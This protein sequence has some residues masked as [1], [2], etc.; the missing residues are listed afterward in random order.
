MEFMIIEN[1]VDK[2]KFYD[3]CGV[4]RIFIDTERLGK[5]ERQGHLNTVISNHEISD[6]KKIKP[7]LRQA[8]ILV[9]INPFHDKTSNEVEEAIAAGADIIMLP[10]FTKP[11]EVSNFVKYVNGRVKVSLLLETP[12]ALFR[13]E[14]IISISGIDEIH[15]GLNDMH[16]ALGLDFMLEIYK[17]P[18]L[19]FACAKIRERGI[20]LG[21]GGIA[22][23]E[24][25]AVK[26]KFVLAEAYRLGCERMILS[27][28]FPKED[29]DSFELE[30]CK[31]R[32]AN[33]SSSKENL[34]ASINM[35]LNL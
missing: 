6:I 8:K 23:L 33:V 13:L 9:R 19:E 34:I 31:L 30:L 20:S 21:I 10:M 3:E 14:D 5:T 12:A 15:I 16:L 18:I 17:S 29:P 22:P 24:M 26:G 11:S 4:D 27:R 7:L 2:C 32:T 1:D 35:L 25:G 28:A